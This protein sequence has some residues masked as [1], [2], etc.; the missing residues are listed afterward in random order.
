MVST[1]PPDDLAARL[2]GLWS[3]PLPD[4][5]AEALAAVRAVYTD[6][7]ELNGTVVAAADLVDRAR[8]MQ[9]SYSGL[10]H[11]LL[12]RVDTP[13][14]LV[15]AFRL[16]G[17]HT[18]PLATPLGTVPATGRDRARRPRAPR[19][20][21]ARR[22]AVSGAGPQSTSGTGGPSRSSASTMRYA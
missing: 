7:V 17:T 3:T 19:A 11:R 13:D 12:D 9:R 22:G 4:D 5:D 14:R 1:P 6:P 20:R 10:R 8:A 16:Q 18:G 15:I 21:G 2:M